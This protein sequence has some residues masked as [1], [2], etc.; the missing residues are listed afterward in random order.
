MA[1]TG[2]EEQTICEAAGGKSGL[3]RLAL[4]WHARVLQDEVVSHA[5]SQGFHS[6]H[7]ERLTA[8]WVEALGGLAE[9]SR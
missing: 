1:E 6:E 5:F 4:A 7:L 2:G 3:H 8:Y 9:Y